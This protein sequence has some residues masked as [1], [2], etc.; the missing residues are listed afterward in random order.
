[1]DLSLSSRTRSLAS[2]LCLVAATLSLGAAGCST[3]DASTPR[4][5]AAPG[6]RVSAAKAE[7]ETYTVEMKSS[8]SYT[9]GAQGTVEVTLTPK[10]AYHTNDQYPYKFKAADPA[11]DGVTFPKPV[12]GR[13]DGSFEKTKGTF[14]VP[15]V[16]T[17]AGKVTIS[18]TFSMSV[19]SDAN[20]IMDK[21]T[22]DLAVDVK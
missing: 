2:G 16:A 7:T 6:G 15:F 3:A 17:K 22:L 14:N 1:M 18:G 4:G 8:G 9:A 11:P 13:A 5:N 10:G 19:C 21:V 20:C 12:M